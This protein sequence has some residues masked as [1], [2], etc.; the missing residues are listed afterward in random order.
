MYRREITSAM[1]GPVALRMGHLPRKLQLGLVS[2]PELV[3]LC[4]GYIVFKEIS[5]FI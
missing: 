5:T 1:H 3:A 4:M 2:G